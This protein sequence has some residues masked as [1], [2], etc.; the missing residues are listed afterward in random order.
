MRISQK[1]FSW[2]FINCFLFTFSE[3]EAFEA[4]SE[5]RCKF[6]LMHV[7]NY[8]N[9][10]LYQT[11]P[12]TSTKKK[13]STRSSPLLASFEIILCLILIVEKEHKIPNFANV[14]TMSKLM[15]KR[16]PPGAPLQ[17]L[18]FSRLSPCHNF[19]TRISTVIYF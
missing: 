17:E 18:R 8:Y 3:K 4:F 16:S 13:K 10:F 5:I 6:I 19:S 14:P 1:L 9:F 15:W 2:I 11:S 7:K 12:A